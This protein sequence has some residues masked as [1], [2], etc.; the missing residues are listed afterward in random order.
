MRLLSLF[1]VFAL[2][3]TGIAAPVDNNVSPASPLL[4]P[5]SCFSPACVLI[6]FADYTQV[7]YNNV[8]CV[9]FGQEVIGVLVAECY[10][11]LWD[12][13]DECHVWK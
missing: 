11:T 6:T 13:K 2:V 7:N 1:S 10:C 5:P 9:N 12:G 3:F 8:Q 4:D